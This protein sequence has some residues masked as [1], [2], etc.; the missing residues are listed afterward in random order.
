MGVFHFHVPESKHELL[1]YIKSFFHSVLHLYQIC[2][3]TWKIGLYFV[4]CHLKFEFT[5]YEIFFAGLTL[6]KI[7]FHTRT[8]KNSFAKIPLLMVFFT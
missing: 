8:V 2:V 6:L 1:V 3:G 5:C 7:E 4:L